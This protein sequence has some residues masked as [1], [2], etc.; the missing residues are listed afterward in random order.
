MLK[1]STGAAVAGA[2]CDG[3][4]GAAGPVLRVGGE[5]E[6]APWTAVVLVRGATADVAGAWT[7]KSERIAACSGPLGGGGAGGGDAFVLLRIGRATFVV[8]GGVGAS[9]TLG[10]SGSAFM[11]GDVPPGGI[12]ARGIE[13]TATMVEPKIAASPRAR[14]T[15]NP[16]R[17]PPLELDGVRLD[18]T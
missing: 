3:G 17:L 7:R 11:A 5:A 16:T 1:G 8:S 6:F 2:A 9:D 4:A 13:R 12:A 14:V 10:P 18:A 15:I